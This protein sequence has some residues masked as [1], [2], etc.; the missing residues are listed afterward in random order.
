MVPPPVILLIE[1][2]SNDLLFMRTAMEAVGIENPVHEISD[3]RQAKAYL[4][5]T[6]EYGDRK[7]Y[8]L[9]Y[10]VLLDLKLPHVMGLDLLRWMRERP[11]FRSTVVL[12]LTAS[13]NPSDIDAAYHA[14][15]SG[16]LVKTSRF[17]ALQMVIRAIKDFWLT[18]NRPGSSFLEESP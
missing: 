3:G 18:H 11:E 4:S 6:G 17:D 16:Y 12:I 1:D 7:K 9:P 15:A 14:G 10:L 8:P 2:D 5:G 13:N